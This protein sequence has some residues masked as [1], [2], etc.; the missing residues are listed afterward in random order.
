MDLHRKKVDI[1]EISENFDIVDEEYQEQDIQPIYDSLNTF[2]WYDRD[3]FMLYSNS[4]MSIRK[5]S[6]E[7]KIGF[8]SIYNTIRKCKQKLKE[9]QSPKD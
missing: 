1:I 9:H 8:M 4:G 3:L 5:L 6:R 2:D 7:T